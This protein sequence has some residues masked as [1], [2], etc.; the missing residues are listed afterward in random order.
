[1]ADVYR[2]WVLYNVGEAYKNGQRYLFDWTM[3]WE[4]E[5]LQAYYDRVK[6][7]IRASII[8][9]WVDVPSSAAI[10]T[11]PSYIDQISTWEVMELF[12]PASFTLRDAVRNTNDSATV[13]SHV[14][15]N[16]SNAGKYYRF[17]WFRNSTTTAYEA[18]S[19]WVWIKTRGQDPTFY[20]ASPID[21]Q[22]YYNHSL[23]QNI[24]RKMKH[25]W[26][27]LRM[28]T[29]AVR[30][31][32]STDYWISWGTYDYQFYAVNYI[33]EAFT[34]VDLWNVNTWAYSTRYD[35]SNLPSDIKTARDNSCWISDS[36]SI[37]SLNLTTMSF[38]SWSSS[39]Y[40]NLYAT[41]NFS[42]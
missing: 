5:Q 38:W 11:Y 35:C 2:D 37:N 26:N 36:E 32:K 28:S 12:V 24:C 16:V 40:Y 41:M 25:D 19:V 20:Y 10:D 8:N 15:D 7:E 3:R 14:C 29:L 27:T 21:E 22:R 31:H 42:N 4:Y 33:W 18:W 9:K 34:I 6:Q 1:M 13:T 17:F 39:S 23:Y 30:E